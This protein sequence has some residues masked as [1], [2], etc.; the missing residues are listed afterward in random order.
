MRR[1]EEIV[2]G[3]EDLSTDAATALDAISRATG[4]AGE[5]ASRIAETATQ[6]RRQVETLSGQIERVAMVA[7][8]ARE[9][10]NALSEQATSAAR[11]QA[12][13]EGAIRELGEVAT[14]LQRIARHFAVDH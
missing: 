7:K 4:E 13:L 6:Q 12:D 2:G 1:G 3:V 9:E 10:S 8:R 14:E 5:H 11:G